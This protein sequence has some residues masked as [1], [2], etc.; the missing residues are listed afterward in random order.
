MISLAER[1]QRPHLQD[2][3]PYASAR[4]SM[5][6]GSVWLNANESPFA[7]D[8]GT[9]L[10]SLNRYPAFQDQTLIN[11]YADYAEVAAEQVLVSR[12]SDEAI[13]L[14]I[15]AFCEPA[16]DAIVICTPTYGMYAISAVTH[17][18]EVIDVPLTDTWQLDVKALEKAAERAK[19]MF[20]CNPSNPLGNT[21]NLDD[22]QTVLRNSPDTLVVVD[23]AYIEF[24]NQPSVT[25]WLADFPN[26]VVLRT[27]SKAFALASIRCGFAL[28]SHDIIKVLQKVIAPY[29]L[30]EPTARIAAQAL[31]GEGRDQV[32][33]QVEQLLAER[34]RM[35][36]AINDAT[37]NFSFVQQVYPSTTNFLLVRVNDAAQLVN[38]CSVRG[39]LIR[40]QSAQRGLREVVRISIGSVAENNA[41]LDALQQFQEE[42]D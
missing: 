21:L 12:G 13:D 14:L 32:A 26:L 42:H 28:A 11:R 34:E 40:N 6:G 36:A 17:G 20:L 29:P 2:L 41:L 31:T 22:I 33:R 10:A 35:C 8:Y 15:R 5:S 27:L 25:S 37:T 23:E 16:R 30:P 24:S 3:V 7:N 38:A 39:I 9:G 18:A 19:I 1:L 4:R